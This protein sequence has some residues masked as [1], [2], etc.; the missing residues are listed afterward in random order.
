MEGRAAAALCGE[1]D[2]DNE[3]DAFVDDMLSRVAEQAQSVQSA[4]GSA[5]AFAKDIPGRRV[6]WRAAKAFQELEAE[7]FS[8]FLEVPTAALGTPVH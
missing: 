8:G 3:K 1:S 4:V 6:S 7:L 5:S 2:S